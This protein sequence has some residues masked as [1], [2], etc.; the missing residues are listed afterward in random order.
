MVL[1]HLFKYRNKQTKS[2]N[3]RHGISSSYIL[4]HEKGLLVCLIGRLPEGREVG[5]PTL[6]NLAYAEG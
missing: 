4:H 1:C 6:R 2:R 3:D 5:I